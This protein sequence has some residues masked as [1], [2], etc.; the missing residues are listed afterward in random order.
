MAAESKFVD[1]ALD[2]ANRVLKP[3][4]SIKRGAA[5]FYEVT[6]D[7]R[8]NITV[9]PKRPMRG[10]SAFQTDLCV[11][12]SKSTEVE[13]PRVVLE[14]KEGISTHDVIT[15]SAKARKHKQ[16]YPYLRY[17]LIVSKESSVPRRFFTHNDSLDF[18]GAL[19]GVEA[20][21]L[22]EFFG[23]LISAEV[24]TSKRLEKIAFDGFRP[25]L[26]RSEVMLDF[27]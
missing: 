22:S 26:F 25:K 18:F 19:L 10:S 16:V 3:P 14:F 8:L 24:D 27:E 6:V 2:A 17:G 12:E 1:I 21:A 23:R 13:I 4:L 9:D 15:Y 5:L 11:F 7:N 20:S